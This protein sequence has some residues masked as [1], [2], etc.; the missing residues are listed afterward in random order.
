MA[1]RKPTFSSSS[2]GHQFRVV[3]Q[4][5]TNFH[6]PQSTL[7]I[8]VRRRSPWDRELI[9]NAY[10][11]AVEAGYR[12]Y[13]YGDCHVDSLDFQVFQFFWERRFNDLGNR[14]LNADLFRATIVLPH[15]RWNHHFNTECLAT[16]H[17]LARKMNCCRWVSVLC[18]TIIAFGTTASAGQTSTAQRCGV[19]QE[20]QTQHLFADPDGK[21][22][23]KEYP[24][25][26]VVPELNPDEG[27]E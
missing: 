21:N 5:I 26:N 25:L 20:R 12:F 23:W 9:L 16:E 4:L 11:H 3:D 18:L 14:R 22:E 13:S 17:L 2:L 27:G 24:S 7:I 15:Q 19:D 8:L 6:L 1:R 10:R